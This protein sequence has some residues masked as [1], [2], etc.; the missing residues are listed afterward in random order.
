MISQRPLEVADRLVPG[1]WESDLIVGQANKSFVGTLVERT[2]RF[3]VLLHLPGGPGDDQ[4]IAALAATLV[5]LSVEL[6][7][8]VTWDQGIEMV[9]HARLHPRHR[10]P[11]VL[12]RGPLAVAAWR[13]RE[14]QRPAAQYLPKGSDLR[15]HSRHNLDAIAQALNQRPRQTLGWKTPSEALSAVVAITA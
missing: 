4:V 3:V 7:R 13:Q 5:R 8:S 6:R 11:G 1:H 15:A 12:R 9:N 10:R 14:H 2:T